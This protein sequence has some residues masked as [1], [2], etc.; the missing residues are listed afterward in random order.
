MGM[1]W[2]LQYL[3]AMLTKG[4]DVAI[5][6]QTACGRL[7]GWNLDT[8]NI[9][10]LFGQPL[11]QFLVF[12][13][14]LHLQA[15]LPEHVGI[16]EVMVQVTVGCQQ[17]KG[18]QLVIGNVMVEG[19]QFLIIHGTTVNNDTLAGIV[20]HDV[21]VFLQ[22]IALYSLNVEHEMLSLMITR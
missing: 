4:N 10:G 18:L 20:T 14:N 21:T 8:E 11:H 16:A 7:A 3:Q 1:T 13:A 9:S 17:M 12:N 2:G 22:R 15:V 5:A 19:G 6:Q